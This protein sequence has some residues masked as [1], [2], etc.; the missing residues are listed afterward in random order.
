MPVY[1]FSWIKPLIINTCF[2]SLTISISV[3]IN[4][5]SACQ[6]AAMLCHHVSTAAQN[7]DLLRV[8]GFYL[9][10]TAGVKDV[11]AMREIYLDSFACN[12]VSYH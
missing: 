1:V 6:E 5:R 7:M 9:D 12:M 3:Y 10:I 8:S 2:H 11:C 4:S